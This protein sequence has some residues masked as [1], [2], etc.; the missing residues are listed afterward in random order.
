MGVRG[1]DVCAGCG[2]WWRRVVVAD[3]VVCDHVC[4]CAL[5]MCVVWGGL[6]V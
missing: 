3:G 5:L 4:G 6:C 1:G 2:V